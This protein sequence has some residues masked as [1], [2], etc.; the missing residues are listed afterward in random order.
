MK[1]YNDDTRKITK[2]LINNHYPIEEHLTI[3]NETDRTIVGLLWHENIIDVLGKIKKEDSV[4]FYLKLLNNMCFADY[5]DRITFQKQI[6]QFNEMSSLIKTF[7]NNQVYH[8]EYP[9][10][11][12]QIFNPA[13][14]RFTKVLTKYSTEYNN[15]TF[16]QNLCQELSMDKNDMF[17]FFLDLKNKY[18]DNEI[19]LLF[20]NYDITKLDINRIYRYL[21]KYT[22]ENAAEIEDVVVEDDIIE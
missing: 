17:A 16:I 12:K 13:E 3:M 2:K 4:P 19:A 15:S 6:W 10:K 20:E 9:V 5:I 22:N 1:S 11:K 7:K 8:N 18:S 14:V 21:D